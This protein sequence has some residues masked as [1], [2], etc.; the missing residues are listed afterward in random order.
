MKRKTAGMMVLTMALSVASLTG[1][2]E[3]LAAKKTVFAKEVETN[4]LSKVNEADV[5]A[6]DLG[7]PGQE[8]YGTSYYAKNIWD[9]AVK[10]GKVLLSVRMW[11]SIVVE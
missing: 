4:L 7:I 1:T 5:I 2:D 3:G 10:D 9:M 6:E 8:R 11:Y